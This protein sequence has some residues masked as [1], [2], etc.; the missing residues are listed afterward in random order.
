MNAQLIV[1]EQGQNYKQSHVCVY[2][3]TIH[4]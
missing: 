4:I 3:Y 1:G 2:L